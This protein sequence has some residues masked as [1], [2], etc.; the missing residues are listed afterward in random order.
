MLR[1]RRRKRTFLAATP[2]LDLTHS[3]NW[4]TD[5]N[6]PGHRL[7]F[8][9]K[10]LPIFIFFKKSTYWHSEMS[11][12]SLILKCTGNGRR[13]R[14]LK[15]GPD[16]RA[17]F[18]KKKKEQAGQV[19]VYISSRFGRKGRV[20][21]AAFS[22]FPSPFFVAISNGKKC[23]KATVVVVALC[24]SLFFRR[25]MNKIE[26]QG[27]NPFLSISLPFFFVPLRRRAK[28]ASFFLPLPNCQDR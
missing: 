4:R 28:D 5:L 23:A 18:G 22:S 15:W 20:I 19:P 25:S 27:N 8:C 9:K 13:R 1:R 3:R 21:G 7:L 11:D 17:H 2:C 24:Y 26:N 12:S 10:K 14:F 6:I 16:E